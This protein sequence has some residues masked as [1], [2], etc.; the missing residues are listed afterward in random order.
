[1]RV[2][3]CVSVYVRLCVW[4][5]GGVLVDEWGV[6]TSRLSNASFK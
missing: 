1:M 5:W 6:V 3:M 2:Y 4:G